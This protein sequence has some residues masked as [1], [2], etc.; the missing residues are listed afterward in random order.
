MNEKKNV[1]AASAEAA[2]LPGESAAAL[3]EDLYKIEEM[4][5]RAASFYGGDAASEEN[6]IVS[7]FAGVM[8]T[9]GCPL[10]EDKPA[11]GGGCGIISQSKRKSGV[12]TSVPR[13][14]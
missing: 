11:D 3:S 10:R 14:V 4:V 1:I 5:S 12:Y 13:I 2:M 9:A 6:S 7:Q 8:G